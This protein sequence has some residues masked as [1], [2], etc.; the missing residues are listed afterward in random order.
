MPAR[1]RA[2][3]FTFCLAALLTARDRL[4]AAGAAPIPRS[5]NL[6]INLIHRL[7]Q[8]GV[9]PQADADD[10]IKLAEEDTAAAKAEAGSGAGLLPAGSTEAGRTAALT[11]TPAAGDTVRVTY[12]PE[13]VRK[14]IRDEVKQEVLAQAREERWAAPR[15]FP[16]W[17]SRYTLFGDFRLRG[18]GLFY[19]AGNDNTG[20]FPNFNAINTGAPFDVAGSVFSPQNNVDRDRQRE[21]LRVRLG[22]DIDLGEGFTT[23]V[24][25]ATGENNSPVT[26][27]QSLGAAGGFSKYAIWLDRAF[28]KYRAANWSVSAGRFDNPF[29][30]SS[31]IFDDDLG[32]D[33]MAAQAKFARGENLK[34]FA[35]LGAFP[36]FNSSL[37]FSSIQPAKFKSQDKWLFGGQLGTDWQRGR[38]LS[39]KAGVAYYYFHNIAGRLSTPFTPVGAQDN[40]DTD[41]TRPGFA[42]TGNTYFPLRNIVPNV[43][44]N[45]GTINQFQYFGLATPFHEFVL[46]GRI[47]YN[48]FEPIQL[49]LAGEWVNNLAFH[50]SVLRRKAVNNLGA[51][52]AGDF[53]GGGNGWNLEIKIGSAALVQRWDWQAALGYRYVESDA[54]VDGF[55]DS[56]FGNG[57]TNLEG[58]TLG[59]TVALSQRTWLA[60]RWLSASSIAGPRY[61]NDILQ[62]DFNGKF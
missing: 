10:L 58:F 9:L 59:G 42:Q 29:F 46:S 30:A 38:E 25:L 44:N 27:N 8:R 13:F 22:A 15:S 62:F 37:N 11:S 48:R 18:E 55:V 17:V 16:E 49:S 2:L 60:L 14:Q 61:K 7:V 3:L 57:G 40:G 39:A 19:P 51:G 24:R 4:A 12:V 33:G 47:D 41:E 23:G 52:G 34:P 28:V 56:D 26:T 43:L 53:I 6:T 5:Q 35:T 54:T 1:H 36:V 32:F 50:R 31:M 21:R 20:A 45:F